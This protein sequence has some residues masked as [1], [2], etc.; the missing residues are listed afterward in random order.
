MNEAERVLRAQFHFGSTGLGPI[1]AIAEAGSS[2]IDQVHPDIQLSLFGPG[3]DKQIIHGKAGYKAFMTRCLSVIA[4]R[5]DEI[6]SID[7][8]G[9]EMAIVRAKAYRKSAVNGEEIHYEWV[10]LYRVENGLV[11]FAADML[12]RAAVDFWTRVEIA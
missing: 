6:I 1:D 11:T 7:G 12:D 9:Q 3:G 4:S 10:M 2:F 5:S 8:A